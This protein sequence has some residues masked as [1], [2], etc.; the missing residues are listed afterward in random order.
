MDI[1]KIT[2]DEYVFMSAYT[3]NEKCIGWVKQSRYSL[4][5]ICL[6]GVV[7]VVMGVILNS[8]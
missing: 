5:F 6:G 8:I 2:H 4:A 1:S 3:H 7:G